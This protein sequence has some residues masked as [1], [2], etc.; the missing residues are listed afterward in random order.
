MQR[1]SRIKK[2]LEM[3]AKN[4]QPGISFSLR[5]DSKDILDATIIG[6]EGT[7]YESGVFKLEIQLSETYPFEPP[8]VQFLTSVYHPNVDDSGRICLDL[9]RASG[10]A[11]SF[12]IGMW[13]A[14]ILREAYVEDRDI[15][16]QNHPHLD[17][18]QK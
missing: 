4:P 14:K 2:E 1:A 13:V 8:R 6:L 3:I 7:P 10:S 16:Y 18:K 15:F 12:L 11:T 5:E 17:D 9:L